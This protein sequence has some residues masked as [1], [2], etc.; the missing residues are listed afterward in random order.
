M[1]IIAI[2]AHLDDLE[3]ACGGT[4]AKAVKN[5]HEVRMVVLSKSDYT[6]YNGLK[7]RSSEIAIQEG[8]KAALVLGVENL[9]IYDFPTKDIPNDSSVVEVL[10]KEFDEFQPDLIFTH[11][12]FD[13]HKA[14]MNTALATFAA[15]RYYNSILM[16]EPFP[17]AG[18]SYA[19][20]RPQLYIDITE[21][22]E[23][24]IASLKEHKSELEKYGEE[25]FNTIKARAQY[26]GFELIS[27]DPKRLKYAE[28]FEV[29]RLNFNL[30]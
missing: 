16:F 5:G 1:K 15:G 26:R 7:G 24:K 21:E 8:K 11:W 23:L 28:A 9:K 20:F 30:L 25:W 6:H 3:L 13:T 18:R 4:L 29:V 2:G 22:I 19:A 27:N 14:H 12:Q 10:N 17:P